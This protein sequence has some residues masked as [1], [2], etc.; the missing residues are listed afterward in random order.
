[1][2]AWAVCAGRAAAGHSGTEIDFERIY[3]PFVSC[4]DVNDC[5]LMATL[6]LAKLPGKSFSVDAVKYTRRRVEVFLKHMQLWL[7]QAR[8][9]EPLPQGM[10]MM[11]TST[12]ANRQ[13]FYSL[14]CGGE[15]CHAQQLQ[16]YG[17]HK[18]RLERT[19]DHAEL[20]FGA[21]TNRDVG[22]TSLLS[23]ALRNETRNH[24]GKGKK[25]VVPPSPSD[26]DDDDDGGVGG[27][28][29]TTTSK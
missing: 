12:L 26:D 3:A 1:M 8:R 21:I 27:A 19:V 17:S 20:Y 28:V 10:I 15:L 11:V 29:R 13:A 18:V 7:A 6:E 14:M 9:P 24:P 22:V 2:S 25:Q 23:G 4:E 5:A 16:L